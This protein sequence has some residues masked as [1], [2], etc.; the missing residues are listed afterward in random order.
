M[1][2]TRDK[3]LA[4]W[5]AHGGVPLDVRS[6]AASPT[7][8]AGGEAGGSRWGRSGS[9]PSLRSTSNSG[10][11]CSH[12]GFSG[13]QAKLPRTP[14]EDPG[15]TVV[16]IPSISTRGHSGLG[17]LPSFPAHQAEP[18]AEACAGSSG[19]GAVGHRT[20]TGHL[21]IRLSVE[22]HG[23]WGHPLLACSLP[24]TPPDGHT[25][26]QPLQTCPLSWGHG[27]RRGN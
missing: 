27:G 8:T 19:E 15:P 22:L 25:E 13:F 24:F 23:C 1:R 11:L 18:G 7:Q 16:E 14:L 17:C 10:C 5:L 6:L 9:G 20:G 2:V 26:S 3:A 21:S 4:A 12:G